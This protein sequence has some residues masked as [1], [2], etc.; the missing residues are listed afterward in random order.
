M[1]KLLTI[2]EARMRQNLT[3]AEIADR[4]GL[5]QPAIHYVEVGLLS[6]RQK[7]RPLWLQVLNN[8]PGQFFPQ[9]RRR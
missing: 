6:V 2:R 1:A 8:Q 5:S 9:N 3:Q 7:D 4:V